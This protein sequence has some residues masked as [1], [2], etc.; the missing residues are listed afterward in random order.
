MLGLG[1]LLPETVTLPWI[2]EVGFVDDL[3]RGRRSG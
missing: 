1:W 3:S 2:G